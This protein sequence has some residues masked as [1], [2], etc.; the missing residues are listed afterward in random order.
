MCHRLFVAV[1]L[2]LFASLFILL[3]GV[4]GDI[5]LGDQD[6]SDYTHVVVTNPVVSIFGAA[7][8]YGL[9]GA[10]VGGLFAGLKGA[11]LYARPKP[12]SGIKLSIRNAVVI[13]GLAASIFWIILASILAL[14]LEL[15][16][17]LGLAMGSALIFG[18]TAFFWYGDQDVIQHYILRLMLCWNGHTPVRYAKFLD[19][20]ARLVFLQKV[21]GGYIFIHRL[22][23]EHFVAMRNAER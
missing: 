11:I 16:L 7:L 15:I 20:A 13:A 18:A 9:L 8:L 10:V 22:L 4:T 19:Y 17:G 5:Q 21:G 14:H 12:N 6:S 1:V 3:F 2:S 23:L